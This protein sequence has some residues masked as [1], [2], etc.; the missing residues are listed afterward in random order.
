MPCAEAPTA[1]PAPEWSSEGIPEVFFGIPAVSVVLA[2]EVALSYRGT[3]RMSPLLG[4]S[5]CE[6]EAVELNDSQLLS[7]RKAPRPQS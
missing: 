7:P 5:S 4:S 1:V 3:H 6:A 2:S